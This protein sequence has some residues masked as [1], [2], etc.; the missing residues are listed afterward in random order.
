[1]HPNEFSKAAIELLLVE[2]LPGVEFQELLLRSTL[3][4]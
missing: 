3:M 1:M 2:A 4:I